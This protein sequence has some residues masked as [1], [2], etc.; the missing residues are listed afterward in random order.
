MITFL[1]G[2]VDAVD[3]ESVELDV[4]GVGYRVYAPNTVL[5]ALP[6]T[7][8]MAK[9]YTYHYIREDQQALFGFGS[10]DDLNLFSQL[11]L[12]SGVGPKV[13]IKF[14]STMGA[15]HI[16]KAV[17]SENIAVLTSVPGV[18]KKL[19]E[20]LV[21]ELKDKLPKL[22]FV[23]AYAGAGSGPVPSK[24]LKTLHDDLGVA[25]R[26]LGYS[27]DEV[28]TAISQA[29]EMVSESMTLEAALKV[30]FRFLMK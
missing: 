28:K 20:R 6:D 1:H 19:A 14:F 8:Q 9:V 16:I 30:I 22:H 13:G 11:I 3:D 21:I 7:G 18:G 24:G 15:D 26:Q 2:I 4:N 25:L 17:L 12:V 23:S 5:G 10:R 29:G 27:N